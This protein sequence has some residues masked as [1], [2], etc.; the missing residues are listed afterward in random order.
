MTQVDLYLLADR[1]AAS[2][3]LYG[4][5]LAEKVYRLGHRLYVHTEDAAQALR[6]D[7]LLWTFREGSFIP[8]ER[9]QADR[10]PEAPVMI[11]HDQEPAHDFDVLLNL[12]P[13]VPL[14]FSRFLRVAEPVENDDGPRQRAR[15]RYRFY[16]ERGYALTTHNVGEIGNSRDESA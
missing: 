10:A 7:E 12:A 4:C 14:F 1:S 6:M 9:Y 3:E 11:G 16:R 15:E 8:H 5:R 13:D 2:R